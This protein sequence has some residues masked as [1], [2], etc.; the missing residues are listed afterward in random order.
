MF[1]KYFFI[2]FWLQQLCLKV[3]LKR[4]R[5]HKKVLKTRDPIIMSIGWRRYQTV[6]IYSIEDRNGR[7]RML[8]Y[9]P[10]HMHCLAMFWGP[11]APPHTGV[12][13]IQNLSN[14]QVTSSNFL[15]LILKR[16]SV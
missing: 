5:W 9:T 10:E 4:H 12:V 16:V 13:A 15:G 7:L 1:Y 6:P 8:K 11:L 2:L 3:R 14:N